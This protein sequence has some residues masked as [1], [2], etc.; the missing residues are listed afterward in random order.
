MLGKTLLTLDSLGLMFGAIFA[1]YN[2]THIFNPR[3]PPHAKYAI[4]FRALLI[5]LAV[6]VLY[7]LTNDEA[8]FH[9]A[10]T[11]TLCT[12]LGLATAYYTWRSR[13]TPA[14]ARDS[15]RTAAFTGS[16]YWASG[17]VSILFPGVSG[18]DPEFGGPGFPQAPL[19]S[20][21]ML[22]GLAGWLVEN[23]GL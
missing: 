2:E 23:Q 18:L 6:V 16:I 12:T 9:D 4:S 5:S 7:T 3:W 15:I 13:P 17:L 14:A 10:Q 8:R 19:F 11:I 21:L 1:D 22:I 20:G